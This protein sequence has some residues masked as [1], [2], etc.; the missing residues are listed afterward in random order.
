MGLAEWIIDDTCFVLFNFTLLVN[1][2]AYICRD[3]HDN[4]IFQTDTLKYPYIY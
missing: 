2:I 3:K 4:N 1:E